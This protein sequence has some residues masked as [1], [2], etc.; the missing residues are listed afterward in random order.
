MREQQEEYEKMLDEALESLKDVSDLYCPTNFWDHGVR[1]IVKDFREVGLERF[2]RWPSGSWFFVPKYVNAYTDQSMAAVAE[3]VK[4]RNLVAT[5]TQLRRILDGTQE[6]LN[7][8][9]KASLIW[10]KK[11]WPT[12][13]DFGESPVGDPDSFQ[14]PLGENKPGV[15]KAFM[16]YKILFALLSRHM[17]KVPKS[18]LELGGGYGVAADV[19][20]GV[21]PR[22]VY[23]DYDLPPLSI[24]A[25]YYLDQA[26]ADKSYRVG[27]SWELPKHRDPVD[28]F[29]NSFSLQEMEPHVVENYVNDVANIGA[30]YIVSLNSTKGKVVATSKDEVGVFEQVTSAMIEACFVKRGY[31]KLARYRHPYQRSSATALIMKKAPIKAWFKRSL[32]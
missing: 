25:R 18:V 19:L 7:D 5:E 2:K 8:W 23:Y 1:D 10:N 4:G 21:N 24:V 13:H 6:A 28:V 17:K 9:D 29:I 15:T 16:N 31:T 20:F 3:A 27:Q 26:H 11:N 14:Y 22:A 30:E 32:R 12:K